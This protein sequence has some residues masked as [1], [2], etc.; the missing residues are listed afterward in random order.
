MEALAPGE[1]LPG[2][3]PE[4]DN[5]KVR[6]VT[7]NS[8]KESITKP[9]SSASAAFESLNAASRF[10]VS[11]QRKSEPTNSENTP[12]RDTSLDG[13]LNLQAH[14]S[15]VVSS[16]G[17]NI[18]S[19][20]WPLANRGMLDQQRTKTSKQSTAQI[21]AQSLEME[22]VHLTSDES[23]PGADFHQS[24]DFDGNQPLVLT[25]QRSNPV[26]KYRICTV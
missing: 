5:N 9:S 13:G 7:M 8:R 20:R 3:S 19:G 24:D 4:L 18:V 26:I 1:E 6:S 14:V 12:R 11:N 10:G 22:A 23:T 2:I 17:G 15:D 16:Y 21:Q 25:R